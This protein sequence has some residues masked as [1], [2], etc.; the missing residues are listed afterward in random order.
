MI[1]C[2]SCLIEHMVQ[3]DGVRIDEH[4]DRRVHEHRI[5]GVELH[6]HWK[7]RDSIELELRA[8]VQRPRML[9]D[10]LLRALIEV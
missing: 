1:I 2:G 8:V 10:D 6:K 3:L 7:I 4:Y 5:S 9:F